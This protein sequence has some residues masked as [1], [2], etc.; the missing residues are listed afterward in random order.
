MVR[1]HV[2]VNSPTSNVPREFSLII[3]VWN[4]WVS[5]ENCLQSLV[6]QTQAPPFEVIIVD[7]GSENPAPE[8]IRQYVRFFPLT[9][10]RQSHIG[11]AAARNRGILNARAA[12]LVFTDADCRLHANCLATL[13][14]AVEATEHFSFQLHL[15]GD[16]SH[17]V[18]QAEELRLRGLQNQMLEPDG[19]IRYLNT[20]GFA[21]RRA[22][23]DLHAG[24]FSPVARRGEDTVLLAH[25]M[26]QGDPPL[27]V[28]DAIIQHNVRLTLLEL[29]RK[30]M[31]SA[32]REASAYE[33]IAAMGVPIRMSNRERLTMLMSAWK[34]VGRD[35]IGLRAWFVLLIRQLLH[36]L[37]S[38]SS[39]LRQKRPES[40]Q[41]LNQ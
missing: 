20:A 31:Q 28:A 8:V 6:E 21:I 11:I 37:V 17:V 25:L 14:T 23:V 40:R 15:V 12:V 30:E 18:G 38:L 24:L 9:I 33:L 5:L 36:R 26:K 27:F 19:C 39:R 32:W 1:V 22:R 29:L 4:D 3:G 35:S 7:D 34:T 16:T 13:K 10:V 41:S 2:R